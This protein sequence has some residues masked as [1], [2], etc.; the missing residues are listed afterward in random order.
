MERSFV[1][2]SNIIFSTILNI[3]SPI[4]KF[5]LASNSEKVKFYAPEY[6]SIEIEKYVPK[7]M[8]LSGMNEA[9][10]RRLLILAYDKIEFVPDQIIPFEYYAKSLP[11][12]KEIDMDDLVFVALNE[13]LNTT[14]LWTGDKELYKG[15]EDRGYD[16]VVNFEGIKE[17]FN[18]E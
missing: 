5:I 11:F 18:I 2:D 6:L 8:E 10:V 12:V 17:I 13:Y 9:E 1:I 14:L 4:G 16:K 3:R 7:I 15:L